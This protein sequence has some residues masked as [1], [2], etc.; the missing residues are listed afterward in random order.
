MT[1]TQAHWHDASNASNAAVRK[2]KPLV[3]PADEVDPAIEAAGITR[4]LERTR[5]VRGGTTSTPKPAAVWGP[6]F[7]EVA[8]PMAVLRCARS[9]GR[10]R[11]MFPPCGL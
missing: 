6:K 9:S 5:G 2:G 8:I 10:P 7:G 3:T 11:A 1:K 4:T